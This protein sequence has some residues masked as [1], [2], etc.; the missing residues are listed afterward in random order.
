MLLIPTNVDVHRLVAIETIEKEPVRPWNAWD[1][2]HSIR[3]RP[4]DVP[5]LPSQVALCLWASG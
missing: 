5:N 4:D 3:L 2:W 1:P